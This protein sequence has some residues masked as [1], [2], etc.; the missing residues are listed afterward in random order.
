MNGQ[1]LI[2]EIPHEPRKPVEIIREHG[3][4]L[5]IE[6]I[7]FAGDF[8]REFACPKTDVLYSVQ[9]D[10]DV[11]LLTTVRNAEEAARFFEE[12]TGGESLP[13]EEQEH[14]V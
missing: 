1:K 8:F 5:M 14:A 9:R 12:I 10:G 13:S 3:D 7:R 11:V 4:I 2:Q 6:G